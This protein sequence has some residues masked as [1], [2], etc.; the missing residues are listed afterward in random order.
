MLEQALP[1]DGGDLVTAD[2]RNVYM[3]AGDLLLAAGRVDDAGNAYQAALAGAR[4]HDADGPELA[5]YE[6]R[7][8]LHAAAEERLDESAGWFRAALERLERSGLAGPCG[9][10]GDGHDR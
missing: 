4:G 9:E 8:G 7:L 1:A 10:R 5:T 2:L 6:A 3:R